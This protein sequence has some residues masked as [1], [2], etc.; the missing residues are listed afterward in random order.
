MIE[1]HEN[2]FLTKLNERLLKQFY[3]NSAKKIKSMKV[4]FSFY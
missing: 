3:I 1:H 4:I 2:N